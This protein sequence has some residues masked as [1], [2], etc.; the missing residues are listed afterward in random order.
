M[1]LVICMA[2][3][4]TRFHD[5]GF[6][7]PKALLPWKDKTV[8]NAILSNLTQ[9]YSFEKIILLP[10]RRDKSFLNMLLESVAEFGIGN[11][12]IYFV[13]DTKGQAHTA[14]IACQYLIDRGVSENSRIAFHNADTILINRDCKQIDAALDDHDA[15]VDI[16]PASSP[17]Y[18]YARLDRNRVTEIV[19]KKVISAFACS[20]F[21]AF[22]SISSYF[23][24]YN[25]LCGTADAAEASEIFI[26][27]VLSQILKENGDIASSHINQ[28]TGTVVLGTPVEYGLELAK[29]EAEKYHRL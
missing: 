15:Y 2:G 17:M 24:I 4:N 20:G 27:D 21:Y 19:E 8:I 26:A 29:A 23:Q 11:D 12:D 22:S 9:N 25:K 16:F 5:V 14:A 10:N 7:V 6:D 3:K 28:E 1:Y 18:S 13:P